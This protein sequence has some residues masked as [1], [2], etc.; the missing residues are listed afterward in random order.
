MVRI[1]KAMP[2]APGMEQSEVDGFLAITKTPLRLGTVDAKG[3]PMIHPLWFYYLKDRLY[4]LSVMDNLKVRNIRGKKRVY[5]SIDT[6]AEPHK[7][8]KGKGTA[9]IVADTGKSVPI[10]EKIIAKYLGDLNNPMANRI[11]DG[12]RKGTEALV[13]I[14]PLYFSTWDYSKMK[15]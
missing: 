14:T 7:G 2:N 11:M 3:D 13:E 9:L 12:I 5:F 10:T 15:S 1:H 4:I 6:D 8:V